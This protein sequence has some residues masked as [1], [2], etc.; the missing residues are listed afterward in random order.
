MLGDGR[1]I[2]FTGERRSQSV[3]VAVQRLISGGDSLLS[4]SG[5]APGS[6]Y[7][8]CEDGFVSFGNCR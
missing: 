5:A 6:P 7:D 2:R 3:V 1:G 4:S 8:G